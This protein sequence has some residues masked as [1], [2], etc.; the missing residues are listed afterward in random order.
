MTCLSIILKDEENTET[1][2]IGL[3]TPTL[4]KNPYP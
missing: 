3:V 4:E 2:K 1:V